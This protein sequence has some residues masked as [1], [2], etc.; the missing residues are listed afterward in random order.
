MHC[1]RV[2]GTSTGS[3]IVCNCRMHCLFCLQVPFF[4]PV[5]SVADFPASKCRDLLRKA[6]GVPDL[7]LDIRAVKTWNMSAQ[8][9]E[10]F[11]VRQGQLAVALLNLGLQL[12]QCA[13]CP[14]EHEVQS[15]TDSLLCPPCHVSPQYSSVLKPLCKVVV[16]SLCAGPLVSHAY[17]HRDPSCFSHL[18][19]E[20]CFLQD[21][22]VE[23]L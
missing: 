4:P 22:C 14:A 15:S 21:L 20:S 3:K 7:D 19:F 8:V 12:T 10:S 17:Q 2:M 23:P 16:S 9:A 5:Q 6:A 13:K 18:H 1:S 11:Q